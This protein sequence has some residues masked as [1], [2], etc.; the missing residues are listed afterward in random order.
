MPPATTSARTIESFA[1]L[2]PN[3]AATQPPITNS[4][5]LA[6]DI[7]ITPGYP[8]RWTDGLLTNFH[9]PRSTLLAMVASLFPE[10]VPRLMQIYQ[11]ALKERFRFY[12]YGDAMLILP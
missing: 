9:L 12:S 5:T 7:L 4:D 10:G 3:D 11:H 1:R 2:S 8:W 6:T